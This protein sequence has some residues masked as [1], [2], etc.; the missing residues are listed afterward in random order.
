VAAA[1][2]LLGRWLSRLR[3]PYWAVGYLVPLEVNDQTVIVG[4]PLNG[5]AALSHEE[6]LKKWEYVG[7]VLRRK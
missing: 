1:G 4:D 5:R 3:T 7:V 6:F 2:V